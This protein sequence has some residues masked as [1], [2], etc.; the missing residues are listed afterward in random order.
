LAEFIGTAAIRERTR[1]DLRYRDV[2]LGAVNAS[3]V[4]IMTAPDLHEAIST[5]LENVATAVRADRMLVLE[6]AQTASGVPRPRV[7]NSWTA[8]NMPAHSASMFGAIPA[9]VLA[10]AAPL[11]QG[12]AMRARL[13]E[14]SESHKQF[15]Q[16][17]KVQSALLVP[18]MTN[19]EYWGHIS[20]DDCSTERDWSDMEVDILTTLAQLIGTAIT[21]E[22]YVEELAKANTIVQNSPTIL[23]R[24]RGDPSFPMIYISQ[25]VSLLGHSAAEWLSSP[26]LYQNY[27]H[28]E[29]RPKVQGTMGELL[30]SDAASITIEYRMLTKAGASRWMENRFTPVRDS[31]AR[32]V[33]IEG[34][35]IDITERKLAEDRIALLAR[36]DVLTG[37]GNRAAFNDRLRQAFAA[38]QC[39]GRPFAV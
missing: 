8:P 16:F 30:R 5:A 2:L 27:V 7:N 38:A 17:L 12:K 35:M 34:I 6:V 1:E 23:Y 28:P 22:R 15:L 29:D 31:S 9:D 21:R 11:Q 25:N 14:V 10:W 36:A 26:T 33:E 39:G 24:L 37:L 3:V 13:S 18:I 19:G 20:F 4:Q 32:L